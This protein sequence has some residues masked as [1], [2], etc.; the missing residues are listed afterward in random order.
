M[1]GYRAADH[2]AGCRVGEAGHVGKPR[3]PRMDRP[4]RRM[5]ADRH[6]TA[7]KAVRCLGIAASLGLMNT[8]CTAVYRDGGPPAVTFDTPFGP[9]QA[10]PVNQPPPGGSLAAPPANIEGGQPAPTA[11]SRNGIYSGTAVPLDT[12]GGLC[13]NNQR[14]DDFRVEGNSVRWGG[15]RGTIENN[16]LQMVNGNTWVIGQFGDGRFTGQ[17][18]TSGRFGA[19]GCSYAVTLASTGA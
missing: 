13:I 7:M 17:I 9:S 4:W 10:N 12:G 14:V 1:S 3:L 15:F 2:R 6:A 8:A 5:Q 11:R 19:P 18:I 16:G